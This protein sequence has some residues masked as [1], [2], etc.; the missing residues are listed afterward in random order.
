MEVGIGRL[1]REAIEFM[2]AWNRDET[3]ETGRTVA[4]H[5]AISKLCRVLVCLFFLAQGMLG[6]EGWA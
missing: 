4:A 3:G 5:I 1:F 2:T 6:G